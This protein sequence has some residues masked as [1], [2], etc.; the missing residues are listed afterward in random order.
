MQMME[1]YGRKLSMQMFF[2]MCSS[3]NG[4]L[5]EE[6]SRK[7]KDLMQKLK[8]TG[9]QIRKL[10]ESEKADPEKK[11][12]NEEPRRMLEAQMK[13]TDEAF[14]GLVNWEK[15]APGKK[16]LSKEEKRKLMD[17]Y[18]KQFSELE[19]RKI[20][21]LTM[22]IQLGLTFVEKLPP[23]ADAHYAGKGLSI[24]AADKPVFWYRP[25]DSKKYRVIYADLSVHDADVPP[26]VP[27]A[28]AGPFKITPKGNAVKHFIPAV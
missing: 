18:A 20:S 13:M 27:D 23:E 9:D 2:K 19:V 26:N 15:V 11:K 22:R 8:E 24:G 14:Y 25:K 6:K 1:A 17:E 28:Q 4:N 12:S 16:D 10:D 21:R 5:S 7:I 3:E